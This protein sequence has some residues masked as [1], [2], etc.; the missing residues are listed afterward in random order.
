MLDFFQHSGG[1]TAVFALRSP[2]RIEK[3]P[4]P[5]FLH[6]VTKRRERKLRGHLAGKVLNE[7]APG[8]RVRETQPPR[9]LCSTHSS[10]SK[11]V[12]LQKK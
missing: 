2:M 10:S 1:G 11:D 9:D 7:P 3:H 4:L 5:G 12:P 8:R 6:L